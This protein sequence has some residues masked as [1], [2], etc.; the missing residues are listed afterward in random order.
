MS[1]VIGNC[2][3][4]VILRLTKFL[5]LRK[6]HPLI[7]RTIRKSTP[8]PVANIV[9]LSTTTD[10]KSVSVAIGFN[11]VTPLHKT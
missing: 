11:L 3:A 9:P 2:K 6:S 7:E 1:C 10:E 8:L 5:K 4:L